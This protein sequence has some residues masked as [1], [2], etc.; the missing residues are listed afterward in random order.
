MAS[1]KNGDLP[2][3]V[4][5]VEDI[6]EEDANDQYKELNALNGVEIDNDHLQLTSNAPIESQSDDQVDEMSTTIIS[7]NE[8]QG[9]KDKSDE[10]D[11]KLQQ[12]SAVETTFDEAQPNVPN[13][14]LK[15]TPIFHL[16]K[17]HTG[18][19]NRSRGVGMA[20]MP[21]NKMEFD[22][23]QREEFGVL[24]INRPIVSL[25]SPS[26]LSTAEANACSTPLEDELKNLS[27]HKGLT[28][29]GFHDLKFY[30]NRLW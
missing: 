7:I 5:E 15:K 14:S 26:Q 18:M 13:N 17:Q 22:Q 10:E 6:L 2:A 20:V 3:D 30:H 21:T 1:E 24:K 16:S 25:K 11:S 4:P 8:G 9:Y 12:A 29:Q 19:K 23:E 28:D 27:L